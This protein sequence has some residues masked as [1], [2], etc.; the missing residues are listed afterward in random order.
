MVGAPVSVI[1]RSTALGFKYLVV[2]RG[3]AA[4]PGGGASGGAAQGVKQLWEARRKLESEARMW[5][6]PR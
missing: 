4:G 3:L 1:L 5:S 6:G 2:M